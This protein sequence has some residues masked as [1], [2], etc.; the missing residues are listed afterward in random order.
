MVEEVKV[1]AADTAGDFPVYYGSPGGNPLGLQ[2]AYCEGFDVLCPNRVRPALAGQAGA[3]PARTAA[4]D[5]MA[6]RSYDPKS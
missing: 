4:A 3:P 6:T 2:T 5:T 1:I